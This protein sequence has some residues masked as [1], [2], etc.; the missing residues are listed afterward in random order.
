MLNTKRFRDAN[1]TVHKWIDGEIKDALRVYNSKEKDATSKKS[2]EY[3][4]LGSLMNESQDPKVLRDAMLNVLLAGRDTTGCLLTWTMRLLVKHEEVMTKLRREIQRTVGTGDDA[5]NPDRNDMKRMLYLSYVLKEVLRLYPSVPVN[6][7]AAVKT[8]SL[9]TGGGP[10]GT[11]PVFVKEGTPVGFA[12]YL[13]HRRKE[14]YGSDAEQFRPERWDPN[15]ASN[16]VDLKNIGWGYLPFNGGPR[17]CIGQEFAL[18]EAS[19]AI[20]KLLQTFHDFEYDPAMEMPA[21][22]Q[23]KHHLTLVLTSG[24]GCW[25]RARP[26][27][28]SIP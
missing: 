2:T 19:Y 24:D 21:V 20:I 6:S 5:R 10:D 18:L 1:A 9:P 15:E 14:L 26:F 13:M 25:I 11:A 7:R 8:T 3:G 17:V 16:E 12:V 4:F 28:S 22:G 23:E 27:T